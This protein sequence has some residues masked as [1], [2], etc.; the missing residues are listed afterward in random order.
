MI[1]I[2]FFQQNNFLNYQ[3]KNNEN[4]DNDDKKDCLEDF[5]INFNKNS[6]SSLDFS[7]DDIDNV[8]YNK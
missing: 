8:Y 2:I 3:I 4:N 7:N 1:M 5:M 6:L